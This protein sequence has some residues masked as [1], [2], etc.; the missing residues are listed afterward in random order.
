LPATWSRSSDTARIVPRVTDAARAA[1]AAPCFANAKPACVCDW[2]AEQG[3]D[4]DDFP[5]HRFYSDSANDLPLLEAASHRLWS[6]S[7]RGSMRSRACAV[8][9][10]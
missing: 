7:M 2:L 8:G 9:P 4:W 5:A 6:M 3:R 1:V 10:G